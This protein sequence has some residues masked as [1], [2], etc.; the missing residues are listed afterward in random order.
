MEKL[1]VLITER[2]LLREIEEYDASDMYEYAGLP[3]VGPNA[4]WQPHVSLSE[5]KAV[6]RLFQG[7]RNT[8]N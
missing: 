6:I 2:I 3:M 5:T 1:P 4:G 8:V 7:K